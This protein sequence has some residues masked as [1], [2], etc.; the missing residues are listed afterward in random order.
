M[1]IKKVFNNNVVLVIEKQAEEKILMGKGIGYQKFPGDPVDLT[2]LEKTFVLNDDAT[3]GKLAA[4]FDEVPIE[5]INLSDY[6]VKQG[7]EKLGAH[8]TDNLL[9]PLADHINFA[10]TRAKEGI[11]IDYPLK[12]EI[13]HMYPEEVAFSEEAI[14]WMLEHEGIT[15][16]SEEV[17]PIAMHFVNARFGTAEIE[18]AF[19]MTTLV[20]KILDIINYHYLIQ[21]DENSLNYARL[22]THLRY[23]ILRQMKKE[24]DIVEEALLYDVVKSKYPKAFECALKVKKLLEETM[25]WTV[26]HDEVLYLTLHIHRVTTRETTK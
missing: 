21:V 8:I 11:Q 1:I 7:K 24:S 3:E 2:N 23:F 5:I 10:I 6:L 16:P 13:R 22:I 19:E 12:W 15:L 4:F 26:N 14:K 25:N 9:I 20:A 17:V 18:Q